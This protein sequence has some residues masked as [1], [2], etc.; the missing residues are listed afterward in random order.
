M[1]VRAA[2]ELGG[3]SR[4]RIEDSHMAALA[5]LA[6]TP[7]RDTSCR[8]PSPR[9]SREW[10]TRSAG[11]Y[12]DADPGPL[13]AMIALVVRPPARKVGPAARNITF[14]ATTSQG[15]ASAAAALRMRALARRRHE[16][17]R[18]EGPDHVAVESAPDG[19]CSS[20]RNQIVQSA[21]DG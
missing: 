20:R 5:A 11:A 19:R 6:A 14:G 4:G 21:N 13:L 16:V 15:S 7:R 1:L 12:P 2:K 3:A 18:S 9:R 8:L 17:R 10:P